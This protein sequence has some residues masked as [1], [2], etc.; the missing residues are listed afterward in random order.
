MTDSGRQAGQA[1]QAAELDGEERLAAAGAAAKANVAVEV[2]AGLT[3][4]LLATG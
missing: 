3:A 1:G 2:K 4:A